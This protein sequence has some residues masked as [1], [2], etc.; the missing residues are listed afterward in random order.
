[1]N[2][3]GSDYLAPAIHF[4]N[5]LRSENPD[6]GLLEVNIQGG[7]YNILPDF[8]ETRQIR[9]IKTLLIQF[10][11][12]ERKSEFQRAAIRHLLKEVICSPQIWFLGS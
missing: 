10:N 7:E 4:S 3:S 8:I 5:W 6:I 12:N 9:I 11:N 2:A 1:M